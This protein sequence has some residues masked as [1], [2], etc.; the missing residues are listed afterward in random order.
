MSSSFVLPG[1]VEDGKQ[2]PI[3]PVKR[4]SSGTNAKANHYSVSS[5]STPKKAKK[6]GNNKK[7]NSFN[8]STTA[9]PNPYKKS[10]PSSSSVAG[11]DGGTVGS[12]VDD[13]VN[14]GKKL[15]VPTVGASTGAATSPASSSI[16]DLIAESVMNGSSSSILN[17]SP[18]SSRGLPKIRATVSSGIK[19][20]DTNEIAHVLI[21]YDMRLLW[22]LKGKVMQDLFTLFAHLSWKSLGQ[23]VNPVYT[24]MQTVHLRKVENG[25]NE[26]RRKKP[27]NGHAVGY[28]IEALAVVF[29]VNPSGFTLEQ[30]LRHFENTLIS[31]IIQDGRSAAKLHLQLFKEHVPTLYN[32]FM[33][34]NYRG[35][36]DQSQTGSNAYANEDDVIDDMKELFVS[37]FN[38][39]L[40]GKLRNGLAWDT[41]LS[42]FDIKSIL[43]SLGYSSFNE[44]SK[45][46]KF[47]LYKNGRFPETEWNDIVKESNN[48]A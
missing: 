38:D 26:I 31:S 14:T 11:G 12:G 48:G 8:V 19:V 7:T 46:D 13:V 24:T 15:F 44:V 22:F 36:R 4:K 20:K 45:N 47:S 40:V 37:T 42:D 34:G 32:N 33:S 5:F 23:K 39:G 17:L 21:I 25:P 1:A 2:R 43:I 3:S 9:V 29:K 6:Q 27:A 16:G 41:H 28:P 35:D 30:E 10:K 18:G